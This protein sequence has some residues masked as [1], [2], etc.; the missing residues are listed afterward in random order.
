VREEKK[1][2]REEGKDEEGKRKRLFYT[3]FIFSTF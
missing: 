1:E 2:K 3:Y